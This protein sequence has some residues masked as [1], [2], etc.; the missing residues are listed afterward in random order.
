MHRGSKIAFLD[1]NIY[2]EGSGLQI[3][4]STVHH[5]Y[6]FEDDRNMIGERKEKLGKAM[7]GGALDCD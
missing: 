7:N 5:G 6:T 4:I 1:P 3:R 2:T